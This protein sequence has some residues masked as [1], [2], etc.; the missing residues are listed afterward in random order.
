MAAQTLRFSGAASRVRFA[1]PTLWRRA[2]FQVS[3]ISAVLV[4]NQCEA[5]CLMCSLTP[6]TGS[7][8]SFKVRQ[9][10]SDKTAATRAKASNK[11]KAASLVVEPI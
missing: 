8:V 7:S 2:F 11:S 5:A 3:K 4:L 1:R 10:S 9:L 6:T